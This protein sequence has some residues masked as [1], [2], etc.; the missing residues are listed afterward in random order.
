[1]VTSPIDFAN[2]LL[3]GI[4]QK[5]LSRLQK[6]QNCATLVNLVQT[7]ATLVIEYQSHIEAS[8]IK[9][10]LFF[11]AALKEQRR[12]IYPI[13]SNSIDLVAIYDLMICFLEVHKCNTKHILK[14]FYID[15]PTLWNALPL[16]LRKAKSLN[17][18]KEDLNTHIF[19]QY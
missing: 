12:H 15:A 10:Q 9:F 13:Q 2:S 5:T 3:T 11:L 8:N 16:Y 4:S 14:S 17:Q 19:T 1:M 7:C 18:F 6:V